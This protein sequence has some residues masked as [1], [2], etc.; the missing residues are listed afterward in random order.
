[1]LSLSFQDHL[2]AIERCF[3]KKNMEGILDALD[4]EKTVLKALDF[5]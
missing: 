5:R 2:D 4:A 1:M 3:S